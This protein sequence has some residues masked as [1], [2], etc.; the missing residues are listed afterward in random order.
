MLLGSIGEKI[1]VFQLLNFKF[2][3]DNMLA[4]KRPA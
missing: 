2:D 4:K 1:I 3:S